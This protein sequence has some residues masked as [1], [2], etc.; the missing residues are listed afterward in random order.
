MGISILSGMVTTA[1]AGAF[2]FG[3]VLLTF[4]KFAVLI[5]STICI[6][7]LVS[8]ILYGALL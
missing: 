2:L 6:A 1:V 7:F 8:M 5:T 3:G 4:Y